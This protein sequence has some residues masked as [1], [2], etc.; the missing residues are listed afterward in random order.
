MRPLIAIIEDPRRGP[1]L[2]AMTSRTI[3]ADAR[4]DAADHQSQPSERELRLKPFQAQMKRESNRA[5]VPSG[6]FA[7]R[8][9]NI[10]ALARE[11]IDIWSEISHRSDISPEQN[12]SISTLK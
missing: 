3:G 6:S 5:I 1:G 7:I 12:Q 8:T 11:I 10:N 4:G 9:D 2:R